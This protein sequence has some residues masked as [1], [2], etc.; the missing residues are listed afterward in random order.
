M[1]GGATIVA[2]ASGRPPCA[3]AVVRISGPE[4]FAAGR[5][6]AGA[7]PAPRRAALRA[8]RHPATGERLDDALVLAFPAPGSATGE[9]VVELHC[10]GSVAVVDAVLGALVALP[11]VR[12]AAAG[13]FTRRA[14]DHGRLDLTQVEGLADLLEAETEVQRRQA[15]AQASGALRRAAAGWAEQLTSLR[16]RIEAQL[17]FADEGDVPAAEDA[18]VRAEIAS[19]AAGIAAALNGSAGAERVR[20]GLVVAIVGAPNVGKSTLLNALAGREAA[21]VSPHAGTTRDLIEVRAQ[22]G[23]VPVTLVDTAGLR[24]TA[25]PVEHAGVA[26]A[27][28]RAGTADLVLHCAPEPPA[29]GW[30][31]QPVRTMIDRSGLEPGL[32]GG[33][34]RISARTGAGLDVLRDWLGQA[35]GAMVP[36]GEAALVTRARQ[37]AAL[38]DCR[39]ALARAAASADPELC[40]EELRRAA[41]A[42]AVLAGRAD[43]EAVLDALFARFCIGK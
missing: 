33:E 20:D 3:L 22:F 11:G 18:A 29:D 5:A 30:L 12:M 6:L 14:F 32:V 13:E 28:A 17:D 24:E 42:L 1:I 4:A 8:L 35:V 21:L 43:V 2:L 34:L 37:R 31:G 39:A 15:L 41:H 40:A 9:D 38:A 23:G 10:H 26:R 19:V 27:R 16:A 36:L 7:L 25:D